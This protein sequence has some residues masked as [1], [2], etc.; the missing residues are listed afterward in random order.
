MDY[1]DAATTGTLS[2]HILP[3][4]DLKKMLSHIEKTLSSTLH[5]PVSSEDTLHF[6][7]YLHTHD[8]FA[9]KQFLLLINVPIQ[10]QSQQLSIYKIFTLN[11]PHGNFTAHYDISTKYLGIT[12]D[13]TMTVE[14][15]PQQLRICQEAKEQFCTNPTPFQPLENPLSCITALYAK[16]TSSI[17]ARCSLQIR[18]SS[19]ASMSSQL[20]PNVWILTMAPSAAA[21]TITLICLGETSQLIEIRKPIHI[22][23]LPTACSATSPNFHLPPHYEGPHLEVNISLDVSNLNMINISS[24]NICIWQHLEKYWNESQLQHLASIPSIPVG[25][26]YSHM[27]KGIQHITP[28]SPEESTG[29]TDSIWTLFSYTG[30]YVMAIG[31]L[32]P[33]DLGIFCCYFF[34][35]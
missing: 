26:L 30:V 11:I 28:F 34:W 10:D 21:A 24:I 20:A 5:L 33:S 2:L 4:M 6:Y 16:H 13:E 32:I 19:D 12:Q 29:D 3:I 27:A 23:C 8:L 17:S 15:L 14:I 22:L 9:N 1:I 7:F 35:C 31:L 18:K 25:Q